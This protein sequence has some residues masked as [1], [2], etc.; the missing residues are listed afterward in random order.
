M[1]IAIVWG[2]LFASWLNLL[3]LPCFYLISDDITRLGA[4]VVSKFSKTSLENA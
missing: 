1:A 2:L 3:F 4:R